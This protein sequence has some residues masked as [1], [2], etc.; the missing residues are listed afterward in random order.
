MNAR[1]G[2]AICLAV[3]VVGG[4]LALVGDL[5]GGGSAEAITD[6]S[7]IGR[8]QIICGTLSQ[9]DVYLLD[10]A[11]GHTWQMAADP[12]T[13]MNRWRPLPPPVERRASAEDQIRLKAR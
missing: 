9:K 11:N 7:A 6:P 13:G 1:Q 5:A 4:V 10:T 2:F 3:L 8:F 12:T